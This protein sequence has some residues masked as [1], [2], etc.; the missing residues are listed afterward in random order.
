MPMFLQRRRAFSYLLRSA[1]PLKLE[2]AASHTYLVPFI[3]FSFQVPIQVTSFLWMIL[4]QA[5][6]GTGH[7]GA[8]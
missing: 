6:P 4:P 8:L 5:W 2:L 1:F 3:T 7:G